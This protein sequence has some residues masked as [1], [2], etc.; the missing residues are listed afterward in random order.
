MLSLETFDHYMSLLEGPEAKALSPGPIAASLWS[1]L[2]SHEGPSL[3]KA[4]L[5]LLCPV[6]YREKAL[7]PDSKY[8]RERSLLLTHKQ[9][10]HPSSQG[11]KGSG[12]RLGR[13]QSQAESR[14][15]PSSHSE[16]KVPSPAR[17]LWRCLD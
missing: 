9:P 8:N 7:D 15:E 14:E 3:V 17:E 5:L 10:L 11:A 12:A 16:T 4:P 1:P 13:P 6:T 2:R